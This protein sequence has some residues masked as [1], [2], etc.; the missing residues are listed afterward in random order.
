MT[1]HPPELPEIEIQKQDSIV[2]D[3]VR[4]FQS[5]HQ[6]QGS[7][8]H[9][10]YTFEKQGN[11][12]VFSKKG[13]F[14]VQYVDVGAVF[15][16]ITT[17]GTRVGTEGWP[18]LG[19]GDEFYTQALHIVLDH[20]KRAK[21]SLESEKRNIL[22]ATRNRVLA[23]LELPSESSEEPDRGVLREIPLGKFSEETPSHIITN[24]EDNSTDSPP[25]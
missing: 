11:T 17:E 19:R 20:I 5:I 2:R 22:E 23:A 13:Y 25:L 16:I 1:E 14:R 9:W 24:K 21:T 7:A 6:D 4:I 18:G 3:F 12:S 15:N 8:V 10:E